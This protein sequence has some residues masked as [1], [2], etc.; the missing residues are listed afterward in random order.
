MRRGLKIRPRLGGD[1][2][3]GLV[4]TY[5]YDPWGKLLAAK[6]ADGNAITSSGHAA[7]KNPL[8]YGGTITIP[9]QASITCKAGIMTRRSGDLSM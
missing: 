2:S 3:V 4:A 8:R 7:I 1:F 9:T 6:D 5:E